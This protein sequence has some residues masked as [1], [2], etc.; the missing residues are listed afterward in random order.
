MTTP[1][2]STEELSTQ[3][4]YSRIATAQDLDSIV[5]LINYAFADENPYLLDNRTDAE[6]IGSLMQKGSFLLREEAGEMIALIYAEIRGQGRAYLGFL[7]VDPAKRRDGVG[8]QLL[9]AGEDFCRQ[10][11]CRV[12]E[13]TVINHRPDLLERYKR[14]GFRIISETPGDRPSHVAGG[15]SLFLIEKDL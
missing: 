3:H 15:Y 7:V 13:G 4:F 14:R 8:K 10:H 9:L 5:K 2:A 11:G 12:V 6:E 1:L